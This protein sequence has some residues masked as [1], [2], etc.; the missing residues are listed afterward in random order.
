MTTIL[1]KIGYNG[2][3]LVPYDL[4][5][6]LDIIDA[7]VLAR[8]IVECQ[9]AH[10]S[11]RQK[12]LSVLENHFLTSKSSLCDYLHLTMEQ[13]SQSLNKLRASNFILINKNGSDYISVYLNKDM[14]VNKVQNASRKNNYPV[15]NTDF[16]RIYDINSHRH[17]FA[18]ST[19][20]IV[21]L[22]EEYYM[23]YLVHTYYCI[24]CMVRDY[25]Q[26][27]DDNFYDTYKDDIKNFL[28]EQCN[29]IINAHILEFEDIKLF[30]LIHDIC[31]PPEQTT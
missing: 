26:K 5:R 9:F 7:L 14:I 18:D 1:K 13:V 17:Y 3:L 24:D 30:I 27:N 10:S 29:R 20:K 15:W 28:K 16:K 6:T 31:Y 8:L 19:N 25:E 4:I 12:P 21:E 11:Y 2:Y 23:T 22:F